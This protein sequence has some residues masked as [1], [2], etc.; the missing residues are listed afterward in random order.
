MLFIDYSLAFN[1]VLP[2]KL[3]NNLYNLGLNPTLCDWLLDFLAG[4][5]QSVRIGNLTS[6]NVMMNTG[7]PQGCVLSLILYTLLTYDCIASCKDNIILKFADS[8][9]VIGPIS[10]GNETA[11]GERWKFSDDNNNLSC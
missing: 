6:N 10:V 8:T 9:K 5:T 4:R 11:A 2:H 7:T 1:A 3:T